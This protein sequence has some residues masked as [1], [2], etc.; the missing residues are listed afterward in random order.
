M[1]LCGIDP[2]M[3][4]GMVA[5]DTEASKVLDVGYM[6]LTWCRPP[7]NEPAR[8]DP[9][10]LWT[11][12]VGAR[13]LGVDYVILERALVMQQSGGKM[14]GGVDRTHQNFGAIRALCELA[15]TPSR[16]IIANPSVWKKA[17]G[18]T[19][20]K[21]LSRDMACNLIPTHTNLF[22]L[23]KNTGLAEAALMALWGKSVV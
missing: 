23:V 12:L 10:L 4:G 22:K 3:K 14:M 17:M 5:I 8:V 1:R 6:P 18:L 16:V 19:S 11:Y 7:L 13:R 20:D 2:D 21:Q 15:F 9:I